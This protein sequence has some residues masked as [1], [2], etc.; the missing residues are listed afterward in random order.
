MKII[1]RI[2]AAAVLFAATHALAAEPKID[3]VP[4]EVSMI[5]RD[6]GSYIFQNDFGRPFYVW[7]KDGKNKSNCADT[8][9]ETWSPVRAKRTTPPPP[10]DWTLI[11][12]GNNYMQWAYKGQPIYINIP[13]GI[14]QPG[15]IPKG[16][17]VL[18]P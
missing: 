8:C 17:H 11:D 14:G 1:A 12:R 18:T 7:E 15:E 10:G 4:V 5:K 2:S 16:W 9:L 3:F 13:E 6:D